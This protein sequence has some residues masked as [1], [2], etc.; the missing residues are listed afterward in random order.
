MIWHT[1]IFWILAVLCV[2]CALCV[3]WQKNPVVSAVFLVGSFL[4]LAGLYLN[5]QAPFLATIQI[6]IYAGAIMVLFVFV[7]ML[8]DLHHPFDLYFRFTKPKLPKTIALG[9]FI[10]LLCAL[11]LAPAFPLAFPESGQS[12]TVAQIATLLFSKYAFP[13]ELTSLLLL[14]AMVGGVVLAKKK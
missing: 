3:V 12:F 13:F 10:W 2:G 14:V 4:A 1:I 8:L 11:I 7:M 9:L 6:L 5:L